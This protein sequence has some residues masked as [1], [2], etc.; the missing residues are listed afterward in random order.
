MN[1]A[2]TPIVLCADDYAQN[3]HIDA[4]ILDLL[5]KK[6][7]TAVS[8]FSTAPNWKNAAHALQPYGA[9]TDVGLH[10]NLTEGFGQEK[11]P[12]LRI[13]IL[14]SLLRGMNPMQLRHA[15]ERQLDAFEDAMGHG[16]D[17][18]DGHQHVHQLPGVRQVMLQ[19]LK[20]RY[21]ERA[22]WVRNTVP[23]DPAWRGKPQILK[24]LGGQVTA[25][26]LRYEEVPTNDGF[27]GVY[28]F[29]R[30]D[31]DACFREWLTAAR[32]G[33]L[34]M[35]HPATAPHAHDEIAAQRVVE[36]DFLRSYDCARM[37]DQAKVRLAKLSDCFLQSAYAD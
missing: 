15:F 11:V 24:L 9:Q 8:C 23:A 13:V 14:R 22:V 2:F 10:F 3:A 37:L 29:D 33:M 16:P 25:D 31:Y 34:I 21:P 36:Y 27:G 1:H 26:H 35:C 4:G 30:P 32:P 7:L 6:R 18:I 12:G 5:E 17:F 19:V 20:K 28:G